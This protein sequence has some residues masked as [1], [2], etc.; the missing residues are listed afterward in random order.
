MHRRNQDTTSVWAH[1]SGFH[2]ADARAEAGGPVWLSQKNLVQLAA[3]SCS[4]H[5]RPVPPFVLPTLPALAPTARCVVQ[6]FPICGRNAD[7]ATDSTISADVRSRLRATVAALAVLA[8]A[9]A[10]SKSEP[11]M[12]RE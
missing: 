1:G 7:A 8:V 10:A 12:R 4:P 5:S 2:A 3:E 9:P 11:L 6:A